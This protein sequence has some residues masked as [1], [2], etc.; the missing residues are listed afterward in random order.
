MRTLEHR[1]NN[2]YDSILLI[3]DG[4]VIGEWTVGSNG[5]EMDNYNNPG[6]LHFW[7]ATYPDETSPEDYGELV[8]TYPRETDMQTITI[9]TYDPA[10]RFDFDQETAEKFFSYVQ[11]K[12]E[13]QGYRVDC[14]QAISVDED[15]EKLMSECFDEFDPEEGKTSPKE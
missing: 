2:G 15:S 3:E 12:A 11:A 4:V 14:C 1:T 8:S 13:E 6:D 9:N 10:G 5:D 7:S